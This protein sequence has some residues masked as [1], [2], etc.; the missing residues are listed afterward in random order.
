MKGLFFILV[1]TIVTM[2]G[3]ASVIASPK[4]VVSKNLLDIDE[5]LDIQI[6][7][8]KEKLLQ[9]ISPAGTVSGVVVASPQ[10]DN[11]NYFRHWI[12]DA[13][14]VMDVVLKMQKR[15][16]TAH[17]K[18]IFS[19][20]MMRFMFLSIDN[21]NS[22]GLGEPIFEVNGSVFAG[23]WGRPQNDGPALRAVVLIEWAKILIKEGK[24]DFV[25]K[26]LYSAE[27]PAR[28]VIKKDLEYV[29]AEWSHPCFDLWEEVKAKHFYTQMVQRKAM[30]LGSELAR[31]MKDYGASDWYL[32]QAHQIE[33][34]MK[35]YLPSA[36]S[37]SHFPSGLV[38]AVANSFD[39]R[40]YISSSVDW[41]EGLNSKY[42]N[43][44]IS[45]I[46]A[47]LHGE[48]DSFFSV[49]D[50]NVLNTYYQLISSFSQLYPINRSF[51]SMAPAIGRYP[52]DIYAGTNFNG[53]NPWVLTTLAMAEFSY[54]SALA[55]M[56]TDNISS[57]VAA[58]NW[59]EAGDDFIQRVQLHAN[60]DGSLS[61]QIDRYSGYM[62]S[63]RDLTWS[64]AAFL[65][66]TWAREEAQN[67]L[68][69]LTFRKNTN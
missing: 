61:E 26:Y 7:I 15:A 42:S 31:E 28:T 29:A 1:L 41:T 69:K 56:K 22:A 27:W 52:E 16:I 36:V 32:R 44:D 57:L 59:I 8:S 2:V 34:A 20:M 13:A 38:P 30:L 51:A 33:N 48:H 37:R 3:N 45:V 60:P 65:T 67:K 21:Q 49:L 58:R 40:N 54:K 10:T 63:A 6:P 50:R 39:Q 35:R 4:G 25:K 46:L 47:V 23:P 17:D 53:G 66:A 11:P 5:W 18:K 24:I 43:L 12:R 9:N 14:L 62:S 19:N 55:K 68:K 64:Y